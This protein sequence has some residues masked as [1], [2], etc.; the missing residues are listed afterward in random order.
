MS[1]QIAWPTAGLDPLARARVLAA[2]MPGAAFA[3]RTV[4]APFAT[5]W[6]W[7]EDLP[8][9][10][11]TFDRD[12]SA[13]RI[14]TR[15]DRG[16]GVQDLTATVRTHGIPYPFT[17]R[18]EPGFCLM[19]ARARA[20]VVMMAAAPVAGDPSRTRLVH[21]EGVPLPGAGLLRPVLA[22]LVEGDVNRIAQL[23]RDGF[24]R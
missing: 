2:A 10:V 6:G 1:P 12:V 17:I 7:I 16:A 15:V 23:A 8:R 21:V 22:R 4:D 19:Q 13:I 5:T 20:Y 14:R 18:L 24:G 9:S 11:P 3:Q